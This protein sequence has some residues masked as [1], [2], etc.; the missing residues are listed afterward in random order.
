MSITHGAIE[1]KEPQ[2]FSNNQ[3]IKSFLTCNIQVCDE[4][5]SEK[6]ATTCKSARKRRN[7]NKDE[8][9]FVLI[10]FSF[11]LCLNI[12]GLQCLHFNVHQAEI[13]LLRP[14]KTDKFE[15]VYSKFLPDRSAHVH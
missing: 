4:N 3:N 9:N 10:I 5:E 15:F 8:G 11:L 12:D 13:G 1:V 14:P 7:V 2:L 6:C